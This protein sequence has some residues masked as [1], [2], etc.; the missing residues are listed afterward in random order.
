MATWLVTRHIYYPQLCWSIY[1]DVPAKMAYGCYSGTT[2][3]MTST[4]GYPDR[5]RYLIA[6]F[7][8]LNGPIC[9]NRTVKWIFLSCLLALQA[10]SLIW[11]TMVIRVAVG[12]IR[13]GNAEEPRSDDEEEEEEENGAGKDG[14]NGTSV[15]T[16]GAGAEWRRANAPSNV[17][18]RGRGRVRL[19]DQ[20]DH[21]ALLGRIGCDKPT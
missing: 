13:T 12:V 5:W 10:L 18:P 21:K 4:N 14:P 17:R 15:V 20:S 19:G 1:K 16:D 8:D 7:Q 11:F 6:P 9:M 2:A 3:E